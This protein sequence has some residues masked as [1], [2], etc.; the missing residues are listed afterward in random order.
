MVM[1]ILGEGRGRATMLVQLNT[2]TVEFDLVHSHCSA[3]GGAERK[4]GSMIARSCSFFS[5]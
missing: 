2:P 4:V 1:A 3:R 5:A